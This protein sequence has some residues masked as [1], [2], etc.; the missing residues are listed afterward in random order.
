MQFAP[1]P[2]RA[3]L[4]ACLVG[5]M[6]GAAPGQSPAP[7]P[8]P[9]PP[10]LPEVVAT[11]DGEPIRRAE[12]ERVARALLNANGRSPDDLSADERRKLV[13]AVT[14]ELVTDRLVARQAADIPVSEGD[15]DR[16]L[17]E[18]RAGS[19][20][21]EFEAALRKGGQTLEDIRQTLRAEIRQGRWMESQIGVGNKAS[22]EE[23]AEYYQKNPGNF[24][25]PETI[26]ASHLLV[27]VPSDATPELTAEKEKFIRSLH[28]RI[29]EGKESFAELARQFSDDV[30]SKDKGGDLGYFS[31][32]RMVPEFAQAAFR[33][34]KE[35]VSEVVRTAF[36]F[37]LIRLTDR[38]E[39]HV[40][41]LE[42][43]RP[44][45]RN[46]LETDRR[47]QAASQLIARLHEKAK[48]EINVP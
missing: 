48:I 4:L 32:D 19:S 44:G 18:L 7:A 24:Q 6:P 5:S 22:D 14:E 11:V 37:H 21:A 26:R 25:A 36:G 40:I 42:E 31:Q 10:P 23:I 41:P 13:R 34:G 35:E 20:P 38:R 39:P 16:R 28:E 46:Y 33:L 43:A 45:I 8:S 1:S 2:L 29:V 15:V 17:T 27:R 9:P 30:G 3:V 47:R 12:L